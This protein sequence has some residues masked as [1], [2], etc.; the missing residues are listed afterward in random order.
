[1]ENVAD[2]YA[3]FG[4]ATR[5]QKTTMAIERFAFGAHQT[6]ARQ[7]WTRPLRRRDQ[8]LNAGNIFRHEGHAPVGGYAI[9]VQ[10][11]IARPA[12]ERVAHRNIADPDRRERGCQ[13]LL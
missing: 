13:R 2:S 5:Q 8:A 10:R 7:T 3:A 4:E 6:W 12:A 1:M 11:V 9:A